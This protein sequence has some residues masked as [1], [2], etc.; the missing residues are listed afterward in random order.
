MNI[1]AARKR[2]GL[3]QQQVANTGIVHKR[4]LQAIEGGRQNPT[5]N[6]I[7]ALAKVFG[8][9]PSTL[10]ETERPSDQAG[11]FDRLGPRKRDTAANIA[12]ERRFAYLVEDRER[13]KK[14]RELSRSKAPP[15]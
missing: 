15:K 14:A 11:L 6:L 12:R 7:F 2:A 10:L 3:T 13:R 9:P 8:V 4:R 5:I 1:R